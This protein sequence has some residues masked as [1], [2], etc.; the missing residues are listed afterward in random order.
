MIAFK[1]APLSRPI[2]PVHDYRFSVTVDD[3]SWGAMTVS[4]LE[5]SRDEGDRVIILERGWPRHDKTWSDLVGTGNHRVVV[6]V[7]GALRFTM[8]RAQAARI[9]YG[10]LDA[11]GNNLLRESL[12]FS[13]NNL[14]VEHI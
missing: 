2:D 6:E 7:P 12:A 9:W 11:G 8:I 4:G 1:A 14:H 5:Y 13:A 10:P 3:K